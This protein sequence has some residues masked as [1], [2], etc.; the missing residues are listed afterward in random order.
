LRNSY[1]ST[2][3]NVWD[4]T[5]KETFDRTGQTFQYVLN[6]D[7]LSVVRC[8]DCAGTTGG[9]TGTGGNIGGNTGD[10]SLRI[11]DPMSTVIN[12]II[13]SISDDAGTTT[14]S[15]IAFTEG[16]TVHTYQWEKLLNDGSWEKNQGA[17]SADFDYS[18][19]GV[20]EYIPSTALCGML[21]AG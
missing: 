6:G 16:H 18:K 3:G 20:E 9:N 17:T 21:L 2:N 7:Q 8:T 4:G 5:T 12:P 1:I 10:N 19:L 13:I 15:I 11:I 14:L